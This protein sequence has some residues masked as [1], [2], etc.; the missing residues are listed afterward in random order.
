M[1]SART[2]GHIAAASKCAASMYTM[3]V[4]SGTS[5]PTDATAANLRS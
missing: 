1:S 2:A 3:N 5:M 4:A